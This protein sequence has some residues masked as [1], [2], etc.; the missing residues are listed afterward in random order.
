MVTNVG[1]R[2][3]RFWLFEKASE[4]LGEMMQCYELDSGEGEIVDEL[5]IGRDEV[6]RMG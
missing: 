1:I 5:F 6:K 3:C 4:A 2:S